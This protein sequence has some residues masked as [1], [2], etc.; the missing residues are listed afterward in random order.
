MVSGRT[1]SAHVVG[2]VH[3]SLVYSTE[4][5]SIIVV[6]KTQLIVMRSCY[7]PGEHTGEQTT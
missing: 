6:L 5:M 2:R 3:V 4:L 1:V 7:K